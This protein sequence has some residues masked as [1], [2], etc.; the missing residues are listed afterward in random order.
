MLFRSKFEQY[1]SLKSLSEYL[2]ISSWRV[3]AE[4]FTR[5]PDGAWS[6]YETASLEDTVD[7]K[8]VDCHLRLADLYE[9]VTFAQPP[10]PAGS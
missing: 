8:S 9:K 2:L 10:S 3:L 4:L 5:E 7:L 1:R 6:H